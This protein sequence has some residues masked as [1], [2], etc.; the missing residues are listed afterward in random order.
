MV[1]AQP[2]DDRP[3]TRHRISR[4]GEAITEGR[5]WFA[6]AGIGGATAVIDYAGVRF[7]SDPTFDPPRDYGPYRKTHG[8]AIAAQ[9]LGSVDAVLLSHDLHLDN[10]DVAGREFASAA[11]IVITGPHGAQ[12]LGANAVGLRPFKS[13][14]VTA[15]INSDLKVSVS[16]VPAQHGPLDGDRD[17]FGHINTEVTGFVLRAQGLPTVYVSGDNASIAPVMEIARHF[18]DI[19]IGVLH[20]G[21]ARLASKD[22]GRP[23]TLTA[24]RGTDVAQLLGLSAVIPVHCEGWSVYSQGPD[25]V[26]KSFDDAGI[27]HVLYHSRPG[28]WALQQS[29]AQET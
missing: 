21:A 1:T 15:P 2:D 17:E 12:R 16:A 28:T 26:H 27:G 5:Q 8:P 23:L 10:F 19:Q 29:S 6:L 22:F 25:D 7:V 14:T 3:I 18:D 4:G 13:M 20:M 11:P 9:Q 24:D